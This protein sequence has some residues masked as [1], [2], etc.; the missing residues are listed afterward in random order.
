MSAIDSLHE[1]L[2]Q[3]R[4]DGTGLGSRLFELKTQETRVE[5]IKQYR[6][7]FGEND[8]RTQSWQ[9]SYVQYTGIPLLPDAERTELLTKLENEFLRRREAFEQ[10]PEYA[11]QQRAIMMFD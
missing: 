3:D 4:P 5:T 7:L 6:A 2:I 10:T 1:K 8:P 11:E 9:D